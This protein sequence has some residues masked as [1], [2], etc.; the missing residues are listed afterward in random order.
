MSSDASLTFTL[1]IPTMNR[2][3]D[4]LFR[5]L[6]MYVKNPL[7]SNGFLFNCQFKTKRLLVGKTAVLYKVL[8][9]RD[10]NLCRCFQFDVNSN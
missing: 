10:I 5:S 7:I 2:Y 3:E 1:C 9:Q 6:P 4:F 8:E